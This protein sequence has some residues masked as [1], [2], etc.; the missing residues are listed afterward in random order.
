MFFQRPSD[1]SLSLYSF[2]TRYFSPIE[3]AYTSAFTFTPCPNTFWLLHTLTY[4][5]AIA[6]TPETVQVSQYF[7]PCPVEIS[8]INTDI[9]LVK[10]SMECFSSRQ[11]RYYCSY[12]CIYAPSHTTKPP[13]SLSHHFLPL[14]Q[15]RQSS[16]QYAPG[17]NIWKSLISPHCL[18]FGQDLVTVRYTHISLALLLRLWFLHLRNFQH[19]K[20]AACTASGKVHFISDPHWFQ[21][22]I[23]SITNLHCLWVR[24]IDVLELH[25][26]AD[27]HTSSAQVNCPVSKTSS[28]SLYQSG[29]PQ[30]GTQR[31]LML[32]LEAG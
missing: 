24:S 12:P 19:R 31:T 18:K 32:S 29:L 4:Y 14:D 23:S 13:K 17:F 2:V 26:L 6:S 7:V 9:K 30:E 11:T 21:K 1:T 27:F 28:Y 16:V 8:Y 3:R 15:V 22:T 10:I 25:H 5:F 20:I